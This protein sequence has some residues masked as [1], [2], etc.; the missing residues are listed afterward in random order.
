MKQRKRAEPEHRV[1]MTQTKA[2]GTED[3]ASCSMSS[4]NSG[5]LHEAFLAGN[6]SLSRVKLH[7]RT[8]QLQRTHDYFISKGNSLP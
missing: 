8:C 2:M 3:L 1:E 4:S 5:G 7:K 6:S